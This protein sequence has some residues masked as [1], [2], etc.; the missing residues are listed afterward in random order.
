MKHYMF[1]IYDSKAKA[2]LPPFIMHQREMA[3][4]VFSDCIN[5]L[6]HQFAKNPGDYTLFSI[7]HYLDTTGV[8]A[9]DKTQLSLGNGIQ[10]IIP[11]IDPEQQKIFTDPPIGD[12]ASVK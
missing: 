11:N 4:R 10:F 9:P 2:Y 1:A 8:V 12:L 6:S 3:I 5:D 7:G